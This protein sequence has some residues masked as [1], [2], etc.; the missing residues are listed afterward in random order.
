MKTTQLIWM[1]LTFGA[2]HASVQYDFTEKARYARWETFIVDHN[3][4]ASPGT[5]IKLQFGKG[6]ENG[7]ANTLNSILEDGESYNILFTHPKW[8]RNSTIK[9]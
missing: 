5:T 9:R 1:I 7:E 4:N 6:D 8:A 2:I 3:S